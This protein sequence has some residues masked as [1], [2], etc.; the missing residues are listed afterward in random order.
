MALDHDIEI[1]LRD[2]FQSL[3]PA[4]QNAITGANL[5]KHLELLAKTH[6]LHLDQWQTLE[7]EVIMTLLGLQTQTELE[8]NIEKEVGVDA[9]LARTLAES[10]AQ[11]VFAP[12]RSELEHLLESPSS[13]KN[14]VSTPEPKGSG[15][16]Q[17]TEG[18]VI[19]SKTGAYQSG[20]I[21]NERSDVH[22]DPYRESIV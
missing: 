17:N 3:P 14:T 12:I 20:Q 11:E 15:P 4:V 16:V 2:R 18:A 13:E 8:K 9:P 5:S 6:K 19:A 22:D 7:N 1:Q 21:S 10:I